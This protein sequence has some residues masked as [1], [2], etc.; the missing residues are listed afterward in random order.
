VIVDQRYITGLPLL[1]IL[2]P[3]LSFMQ[4]LILLQVEVP[5]NYIFKPCRWVTHVVD[6]C[7]FN[8][9]VPD[10]IRICFI[11]LF[12][13]VGALFVLE[14]RLIEEHI[15]THDDGLQGQQDLQ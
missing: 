12:A 8:I 6:H 3:F 4:N 13:L 7:K 15:L 10:D 1:G 14:T 2:E 9:A 5:P 11:F